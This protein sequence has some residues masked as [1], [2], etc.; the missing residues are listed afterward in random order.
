MDSFHTMADAVI[1]GMRQAG[2]P[3]TLDAVVS[4]LTKTFGH[5]RKTKAADTESSYYYFELQKVSFTI[6]SKQDPSVSFD[7]TSIGIG[8]SPPHWRDGPFNIL[9]NVSLSNGQVYQMVPP[10]EEKGNYLGRGSTTIRNFDRLTLTGITE[11][12]YTQLYKKM[13]SATTKARKLITQFEREGGGTSDLSEYAA[14]AKAF[15]T[16]WTHGET[17]STTAKKVVPIHKGY[18][19]PSGIKIDVGVIFNAPQFQKDIGGKVPYTLGVNLFKIVTRVVE[20]GEVTLGK[21]YDAIVVY[22]S[23]LP[24]VDALDKERLAFNKDVVTPWRSALGVPQH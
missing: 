6:T 22:G 20:T 15:L 1:L 10:T 3:L 11:E 23:R 5:P 12:A 4:H 8:V 13:V 16:K 21:G 9:P 18:T 19:A 7:M 14:K 17:W 24:F 2:V